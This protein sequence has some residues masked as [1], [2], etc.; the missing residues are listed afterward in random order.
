[1]ANSGI[2]KIEFIDAGFKAILTSDGC[3]EVVQSVTGEIA[4]K[5]NANNDRGGEGFNASTQVGGYGGG[6]WIGFVTATD[7]KAAAAESEDKALTRALS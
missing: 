3:H 6:R 7:K 2:T 1:M 4:A 5:A